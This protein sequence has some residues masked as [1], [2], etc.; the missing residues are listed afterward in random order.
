MKD[1]CF[2]IEEKLNQNKSNILNEAVI[3]LENIINDINNQD[4]ELITNKIQTTIINIK[5]FVSEYQNNLNE[6][7]KYIDFLEKDNYDIKKKFDELSNKN[8]NNIQEKIF[9]SLTKSDINGKYIGQLK[10]GKREGSGIIYWS[11]GDKYEGEWK[12]DKNDGM[13]IYYYTY[14][15]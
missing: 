5:N 14:E 8:N 10:E 1:E 12:N 13:G 6:I 4:K 7:K 3:E 15:L 9:Q 11:N 2:N